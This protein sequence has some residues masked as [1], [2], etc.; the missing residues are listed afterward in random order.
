MMAARSLSRRG[1]EVIVEGCDVDS[2]GSDV[3]WPLYCEAKGLSVGYMEAEGLTY[4][5]NV[6]YAN[7]LAD[8]RDGDPQAWAT[9]VLR[10]AQHIEAMLPY[11]RDRD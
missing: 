6:D 5:T 3:A 11:M 1:A 7:D 10:A 8:S 4:R 9:R 2:I